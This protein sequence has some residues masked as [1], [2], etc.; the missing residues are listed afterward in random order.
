MWYKNF[1]VGWEKFYIS[2]LV[3]VLASVLAVA[4]KLPIKFLHLCSRQ[5]LYYGAQH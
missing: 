2:V 3:T 1:Q 5:I 4:L